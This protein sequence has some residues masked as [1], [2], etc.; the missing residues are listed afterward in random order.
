[1]KFRGLLLSALLAASSA[2][3]SAQEHPNVAKGFAPDKIFA[4]GEVD[5]V[6]AFNGNLLLTLPIGARKLQ[7]VDVDRQHQIAVHE[8]AWG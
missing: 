8:T 6:N 7:L 3:A 4:V 5:S 1:M 2:A